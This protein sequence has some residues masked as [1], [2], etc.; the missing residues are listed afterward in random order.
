MI[1]PVRILTLL[2]VMFAAACTGG[3]N[4]TRCPD[5]SMVQGSTCHLAPDGTYF[6]SGAEIPQDV[7]DDVADEIDEDANEEFGEEEVVVTEIVIGDD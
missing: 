1:H 7:A 4:M 5:D 3:G 2:L 6:G